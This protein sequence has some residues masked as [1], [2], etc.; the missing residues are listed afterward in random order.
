M[1]KFKKYTWAGMFL[2]LIVGSCQKP[3]Y[4]EPNDKSDITDFYATLDGSGRSRLF[5]SHISNDTV[6]VNI[7]YYYPIDSDNEVDLSKVL[8]KAS[9]PVDSK[10][11]PS[12]DGISDLSK[13]INVEVIAGDGS[14]KKY[15]IVAN[16]KGNTDIFAARLNFQDQE[17]V[18]QEVDAILVGNVVNFSIV[19]GTQVINPKLSY[20]LNKHAAGSIPN[21]TAV[22]LSQPIPFTVTSAGDAKEQYTLKTVEAIKLPKGIRA[23]SAKIMFAKKLK[24]DLGIDVDNMT[25]S[26]A[27]SGKH[28]VLNTR[29]A[30]SVYINAFTGVKEGTIDL[31]AIKGSLRNFYSTS[32]DAGNIFINNLAPNDGAVFKIW[33]ANS[34]TAALVPFIEWNTAGKAIGRKVSIIGDVNKNAIITAP[35]HAAGDKTFAR[36]QVING[37]LVSSTPTVVT[38]TDYSWSNNNIDLIYT[39]PTSTSSEYYAIGYSDNRLVRV[40]GTT[41]SVAANLEK[42]DANFIANAVD[43]A[44]FNNGKYV[45]YNHINSFD[46]GSADQ[47]FLIDTEGGFSGNPSLNTTPGLVW[48]AP[49]GIYGRAGTMQPSNANGTGDVV[50]AV[51]D[52]GFY[53][54]LYF[55]FTNGYVVGVQYDCVD[56]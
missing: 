52:N 30:N 9:I 3:D 40:N 35:F 51:S 47:V 24:A 38:I 44:E 7:D 18:P 53:L 49:K 22:N 32:D 55:M 28:L 11:V 15:V 48:S 4:V 6:F 12:L 33:K 41:N 21:G 37:A 14:S 46:W 27:V 45:A 2:A 13:P 54:Y 17:G 56:L 16:K 50:M 26:I 31:G 43:Y 23:N 36:W 39:N 1:K 29:A 42:L 34:A 19:P 10:I 20:T 8:L 5:N 25:S